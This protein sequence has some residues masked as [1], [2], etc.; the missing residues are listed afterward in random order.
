MSPMVVFSRTLFPVPECPTT[1][2]VSP[3]ST[4]RST[5]ARTGASKD[6][7]RSKYSTMCRGPSLSPEEDHRERGVQHQDGHDHVDH[8][9]GGGAADALGAAVREQ[10]HVRGDQ[11]DDE[12]EDRTLPDRVPEVEG[13]P[14]DA[15][16]VQ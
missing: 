5:P 13:V 11:R 2:I 15:H 1:D 7:W 8:G 10:P 4:R 12:A 6:L 16:A 9:G 14:V 3:V